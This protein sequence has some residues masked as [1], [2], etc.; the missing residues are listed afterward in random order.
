MRRRTRPRPETGSAAVELTLLTPLLIALILLV[1]AAGRVTSARIAV[2]DAAA[3]AARTVTLAR[4]P[5][6]ATDQARTAAT[7]ATIGK[8]LPCRQ[9]TVTI[10]TPGAD[11]RSTAGPGGA[12][13][14]VTV[15][16]ACTVALGDLTGLKLPATTVITGTATSPLDRYRSPQW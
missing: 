14:V 3:Q 11:A 10:T 6:T 2:Q 15:Q 12:L 4:T 13:Q 7:T 9:V 8:G 5:G 1:V 16:V